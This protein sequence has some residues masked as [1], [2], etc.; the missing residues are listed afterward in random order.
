[1]LRAAAVLLAVAL[2]LSQPARAQETL[3]DIRVELG[4]LAVEIA[5]LRQELVPTA[6]IA[7]APVAGS[8]LDRMNAIEAALARLTS[9]SEALELRINR[10]VQDGTNRIGDLDFRLTELEG[11]DDGQIG[12]TPPL[13]GGTGAAPGQGG[14]ELAMGE[15]ADFDRAKA[16]L[17]SGSFR[18]AA[19]LFAAF[20][21]TYPGG[22]LT[23]EAHFHRG[24]ALMGLGET[25]NAARAWLESFSGSPDGARAADAL[26]QLGLALNTLGQPQEAC[27]TLGEVPVRYPGTA[28]AGQ[29]VEARTTMGCG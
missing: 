28:A 22:P 19:D 1:M 8:A 6:G 16:A 9:K 7:A 29:A 20:A 4:A 15:Q 21:E 5:R 18:S 27:V 25:G 14:A 12:T 13:G 10:V 26:L 11:G 2:G 3:A 23:G 24:E 17:D